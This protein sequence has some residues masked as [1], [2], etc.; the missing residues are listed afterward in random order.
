MGVTEATLRD[1]VAW[2]CRILAMEGYADLTLGHVSTRAEDDGVMYI[3]R[4]GVSLAEVTPVD[5]LR[6]EINGDVSDAAPDMHLEAV[7][8]TEVYK[9][10]AD[11]R[12][13]VHGHPPAATAFS[14][15]SADFQFLTHDGVLFIDGISTFDAVPDLIIDAEQGSDVA[16]ALGERST[17]LMRNH[18]VLIAERDVPWAVLTAVTLERA[19]QLQSIAS[20]LG[21]LRPIAPEWLERVH[22]NKYRDGFVREYWDSWVRQLRRDGRA[23]GMP[24]E[25]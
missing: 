17:M 8:H 3:K 14:A 23:I 13:V 18:G 1:Q 22:E 9:R 11:V 24:D 12:C 20:T 10:R 7:L 4:K 5:V 21:P 6:F 16:A 25:G 15:T 2:A 19:V